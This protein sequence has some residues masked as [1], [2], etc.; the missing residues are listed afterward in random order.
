MVH[1]KALTNIFKRMIRLTW[2]G[3]LIKSKKPSVR[4]AFESKI[5]DLVFN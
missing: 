2:I 3:D 1:F 4:K 5:I